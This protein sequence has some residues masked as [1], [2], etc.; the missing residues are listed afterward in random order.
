MATEKEKRTRDWESANYCGLMLSFGDARERFALLER[1]HPLNVKPREIDVLIRTDEDYSNS[2]NVILR[3]FRKHNIIELKNPTEL[4]N[5]DTLCNVYSYALQYKSMG[6]TEDAIQLRDIAITI[7]RAAKPREL[8]AKLQRMGYT[9]KSGAL[10]I[11]HVSGLVDIPLQ[12]VVA[13]ELE[14]EEFLALRVLKRNAK[15]EELRN[16]VLYSD[17]RTRKDEKEM[18]GAVLKVSMAVNEETYAELK[19]EER[20]SEAWMELMK[21]ELDEAEAKG[22]K[23][24]KEEMVAEMLKGNEPLS[25]I[26]KYTKIATERIAEIANTIGVTPVAG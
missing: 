21:P 7:L 26:E 23:A 2:G 13:S 22:R 16:F 6:K 9:V 17:S 10:G 1:G 24:G 12:V 8:F 11:Y 4:L 19:E 20:M 3:S 5:I 18:A 15:K 25:K 14:G